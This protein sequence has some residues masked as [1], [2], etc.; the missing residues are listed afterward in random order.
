MFKSAVL[1]LVL[2]LPILAF[3]GDW[4]DRVDGVPTRIV[5]GDTIHLGGHKIRLLGIDTP[6]MKQYCRDDA[7]M[8]WPCGRRARDM[9]VGMVDAGGDMHC[10]I[11]GRDRYKRLLGQCFAGGL[12]VQHALIAAGFG[13]AEYTPDYKDVEATA[14][15]RKTGMWSGTFQRPK[16]YRRK[17]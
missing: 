3:A 11:T 15:S 14:K 5:D 2:L 12:D 13:V 10:R 16:D 9:L 7:G 6:E 4:P 1:T 17:N 8:A